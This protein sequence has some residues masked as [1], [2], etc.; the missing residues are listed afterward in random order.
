MRWGR[1]SLVAG[2]ACGQLLCKV[3]GVVETVLKRSRNS[4]RLLVGLLA[5]KR[6]RGRL[7]LARLGSVALRSQMVPS[8]PMPSWGNR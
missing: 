2:A 6:R 1:C 8:L 4:R 5:A 3:R 7:D